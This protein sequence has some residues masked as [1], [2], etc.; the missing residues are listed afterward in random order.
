MKRKLGFL[1]MI[2]GAC[3]V[4]SAL[5]LLLGNRS[6]SEQAGESSDTV[7]DAVREVISDRTEQRE[8]NPTPPAHVDPYDEEEV[9]RSYEMT[10]EVINGYGYIGYL[11]IPAIEL[12]L[13]VM[14][15]WDYTR[16]KI[17]PCRQMGSTKSDDIVIAGH[18][19]DRHF[20]RL[21]KLKPGDAA[22]F[23]DM[24][25]ETIEYAV[26]SVEILGATD[27]DRLLEE[28]WDMTLY[29]CTYGGRNRVIV[30][31]VRKNVG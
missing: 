23:T 20:G 1:F 29:T 21:S 2:L 8:D 9:L 6:E 15:D 24:D 26:V 11:S 16:L 3:L 25:G 7:L 31:L 17:A 18:N 13:P 30:R 28:G 4:A 5:I 19:F 22:F 12:E 27:V 10:V 14:E